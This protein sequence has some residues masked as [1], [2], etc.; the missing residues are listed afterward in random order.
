MNFSNEIVFDLLRCILGIGYGAKEF[1][2]GKAKFLSFIILSFS[3]FGERY[4]LIFTFLNKHDRLKQRRP[5]GGK[6]WRDTIKDLRILKIQEEAEFATHPS[7]ASDQN[8]FLY[9]NNLYIL[10]IAPTIYTYFPNQALRYQIVNQSRWIN[11]RCCCECVS[12]HALRPQAAASAAAAQMNHL[13]Q[14]QQTPLAYRMRSVEES[15]SVPE[16]AKEMAV[17]NGH[18]AQN[19]RRQQWERRA[20]AV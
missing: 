15:P 17:V 18:F 7:D 10:N 6:R 16:Q 9:I 14:S 5:N 19:W 2:V 11:W 13:C 12:A 1:V 4:S 3:I 8:K 20:P